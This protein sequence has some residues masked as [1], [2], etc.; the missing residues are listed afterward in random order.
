MFDYLFSC[1]CTFDLVMRCVFVSLRS[2]LYFSLFLVILTCF[3]FKLALCLFY[4]YMFYSYFIVM[5][6]YFSLCACVFYVYLLFHFQFYLYIGLCQSSLFVLVLFC[7]LG[8]SLFMFI[9]YIYIYQ[10]QFYL[11]CW[12]DFQLLLVFACFFMCLCVFL[13]LCMLLS[14]CFYSSLFIYVCM[15]MFLF[16]FYYVFIIY[17]YVCFLTNDIS[18]V[19]FLLNFRCLVLVV[20]YVVDYLIFFGL[21]LYVG[22]CYPCFF[23]LFLLLLLYF[24]QCTFP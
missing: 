17:D 1:L 22:L 15:F 12:Y 2:S 23:K 19:I 8:D 13:Q 24:V 4:I 6:R 14:V 21:C 5:L 20:Y 16:R 10:F 9:F 11:M 18:I 3:Y 7:C